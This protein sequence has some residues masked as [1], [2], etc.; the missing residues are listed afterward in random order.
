MF[1]DQ[2]RYRSRYCGSRGFRLGEGD[3]E[4]FDSARRRQLE[5]FD[6]EECVESW[7]CFSR[8]AVVD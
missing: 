1:V 4:R 2:E 6:E 5:G 3:S 7:S 8:D